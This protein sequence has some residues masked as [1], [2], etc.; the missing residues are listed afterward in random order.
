[1]PCISQCSKNRTTS[2]ST[3]L[4]SFRSST[5]SLDRSASTNRRKSGSTGSPLP[6]AVPPV[7]GGA[8]GKWSVV[9]RHAIVSSLNVLV[10]VVERRLPGGSMD[11]HSS[12]AIP[13]ASARSRER[14][15]VAPWCPAA[16]TTARPRVPPEQNRY[17]E[18]DVAPWL[19]PS[20]AASQGAS[21]NRADTP[22]PPRR[23]RARR[24]SHTGLGGAPGGGPNAGII[25]LKS[26][27]QSWHGRQGRHK[28]FH[29]TPCRCPWPRGLSRVSA[30]PRNCSAWIVRWS[31]PPQLG[32][33]D[34]L[35]DLVA[36]LGPDV[37][38]EAV[39]KP[40]EDP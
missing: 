11:P 33:E 24:R 38:R 40:G 2:T 22:R 9:Q 4:T 27:G 31:A 8:G 26:L 32:V 12:S 14:S 20:Q 19:L 17:A 7:E 25:R 1:M 3:R 15:H 6:C 23:H 29:Q 34:L 16:S 28:L 18:T 37:H 5:T 39:V 36:H 21:R 13:L 10:D 35:G 30:S